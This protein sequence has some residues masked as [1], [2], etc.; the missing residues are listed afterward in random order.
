MENI[1][2]IMKIDIFIYKAKSIKNFALI[3]HIFSF[4]ISYK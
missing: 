3:I 2:N 4:D 1:H